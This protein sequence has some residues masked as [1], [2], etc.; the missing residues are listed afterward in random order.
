MDSTIPGIVVPEHTFTK[1]LLRIEDV[2]KRFGPT[3]VLRNV[4]A[5]IRDVVRPGM[6]QGQV[7]GFL[8]PSGIG[9]T[10]LFRIIAGL[11]RP[12][13][14]QV[15]LNEEST[16]V[17]RGAVVAEAAQRVT[18]RLYAADAALYAVSLA[19]DRRGE[20]LQFTLADT[21]SFAMVEGI[22]QNATRIAKRRDKQTATVSGVSADDLA[23]A[24]Q[25]VRHE[26][27][28]KDLRDDLRDFIQQHHLEDDVI[29]D[30]RRLRQG[31]G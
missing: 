6:Q 14:G 10:Q 5:V 13:S 4:N 15:L 22:A 25:Q 24:V 30:I 18:E 28:H 21:V 31:T 12:T 7:V 9:K 23:A 27:E 20:T 8:G 26:T 17:K 3:V 1:T 29:G 19:G 2:S 16:P 11:E